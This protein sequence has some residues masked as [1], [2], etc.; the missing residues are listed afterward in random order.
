M[1]SLQGFS[2]FAVEKKIESFAIHGQSTYDAS[3]DN[4]SA[5]APK[6]G[7]TRSWYAP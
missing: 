4:N 1:G 6:K 5:N 2:L 3:S 7:K